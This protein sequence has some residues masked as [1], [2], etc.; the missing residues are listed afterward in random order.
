MAD[1][2]AFELAFRG[3]Y[4]VDEPAEVALEDYAR[5]LLRAAEAHGLRPADDPM[6]VVGVRVTGARLAAT[7]AL[8]ADI[9]DF[10]RSLVSRTPGG[11][12]G[13]S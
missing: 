8:L 13:W 10:A 3:S 12:L 1:E 6:R 11:G 9:E 4:P 7:P 5:E 2:S